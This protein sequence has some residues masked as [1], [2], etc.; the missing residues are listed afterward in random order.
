MGRFGRRKYFY[1]IS[2]NDQVVSVDVS[3]NDDRKKAFVACGFG[4]DGLGIE[5]WGSSSLPSQE[6]ASSSASTSTPVAGFTLV[7]AV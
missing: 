7:F 2:R 1:A 3:S 5:I 4:M 6:W